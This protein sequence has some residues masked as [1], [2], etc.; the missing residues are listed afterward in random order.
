M[1]KLGLAGLLTSL[2]MTSAWGGVVQ[3]TPTNLYDLFPQ[4]NQGENGIYLQRLSPTN[5][6]YEYLTYLDDYRFGTPGATWNI[7]AAVKPGNY[8]PGSIQVHPTAKIQMG[9]DYD[10]IIRVTLN[11]NYGAVRVTGY[12]QSTSPGDVRYYIYKGYQNYNQPIWE[13]WEYT[14]NRPFNFDLTVP[15]TENE[16]LF[17]AADSGGADYYDH[18]NWCFVQFQ[19]VPEPTTLALTFIGTGLVGLTLRRRS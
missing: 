10:V 6:L 18:A 11:G 9:H 17:F 16:Q 12:T 15:Y 14:S 5:G 19:A 13:H 7:P 1:K 3:P 2:V 4:K 8:G